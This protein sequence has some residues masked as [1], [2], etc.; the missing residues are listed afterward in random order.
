MSHSKKKKP[1]TQ[2]KSKENTKSDYLNKNLLLFVLLAITFLL[3]SNTINH[4]FTNRDD[5][6][7]VTANILI[8]DSSWGG[9]KNFV[10]CDF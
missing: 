3:F 10:F 6:E 2:V 8:Q 4:D 7:Y 5:D 9:I 1:V